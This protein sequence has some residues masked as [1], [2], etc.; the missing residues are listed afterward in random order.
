ML[1]CLI[2]SP[3]CPPAP[4]GTPVSWALTSASPSVGSLM[5][6]KLSVVP[7]MPAPPAEILQL[8]PVTVSDPAGVGEPMSWQVNPVG[9]FGSAG[10]GGGG[11]VGSVKAST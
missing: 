3:A 6:R 10:G 8:P 4:P 5:S 7:V 11:V 9:Q 1:S 2:I